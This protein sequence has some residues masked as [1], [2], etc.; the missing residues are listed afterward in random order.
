MS[1]MII[2]DVVADQNVQT[3]RPDQT[4]H[5]AA[6]MMTEH[7]I[8]AV[9]VVDDKERLAGIVTERDLSRRVVAMDRKGSDLQLSEIMTSNPAALR[10]EDNAAHAMETMRDLKIRHLPV[11]ER[12]TLKGVVSLRDVVGNWLGAITGDPVADPGGLRRRLVADVGGLR[13]SGRGRWR[14][15]KQA[16][17]T[18]P[19][20]GPLASAVR[21]AFAS[22]TSRG[23][24]EDLLTK[25]SRSTHALRRRLGARTT[26]KL[27]SS[28][29]CWWSPFVADG[30]KRTPTGCGPTE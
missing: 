2:P 21:P 27:W 14:L 19:L 5:E 16:I 3:L 4:A 7:N 20:R 30:T 22:L 25:A 24:C 17:F 23:S 28:D 8:S 26:H 15:C 1:M 18:G 6:R 13:R 29:G 11:V 9:I 12:D 10:P